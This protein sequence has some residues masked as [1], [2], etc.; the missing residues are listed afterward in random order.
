MPRPADREVIVKQFAEW[1]AVAALK[2]GK[3]HVKDGELLRELLRKANV[4]RMLKGRPITGTEF[5]RWHK[6][7][8]RWLY[9]QGVGSIG[10]AAKLLN[11]YLKTS[12]YIGGLRRKGLVECLHPPLDNGLVRGVRAEARSR[13]LGRVLVR[14]K[15]IAAIRN[16]DLQYTPLICELRDLARRLDRKTLFELE[17]FWMPQYR[18]VAGSRTASTRR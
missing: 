4:D 3:G 1:T 17:R 5:E 16:Y 9:A 15:G 10:W 11:V 18:S 13:N 8:S 6:G 7:K 14:W 12:V 2:S